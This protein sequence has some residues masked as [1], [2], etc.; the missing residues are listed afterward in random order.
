MI[1]LFQTGAFLEP[2]LYQRLNEND[3]RA[4]RKFLL[5]EMELIRLPAASQSSD[6]HPL[7]KKTSSKFDLF[8]RLCGLSESSTHGDQKSITIDEEISYYVKAAQA[9]DHFPSFWCRYGTK[10]RRLS[11]IVRRIN[12]VP[13]TSVA[14]EACFSVAG[15]VS[16]K[17]RSSLSS[18]SL[19]YCM[20]LK[21]SHLLEK[22][23]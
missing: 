16:R 15:Y 13:A 18:S 1:I 12:S 19:R 3:R 10:L 4:A 5:S 11:S 9:G 6:D 22:L 17:Q 23:R 7:P 8:T 2:A 14:S 20:V 21:D